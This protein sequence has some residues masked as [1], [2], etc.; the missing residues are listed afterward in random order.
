MSSEEEEVEKGEAVMNVTS[1]KL[2]SHDRTDAFL[3]AG[4][5][6]SADLVTSSSAEWTQ[7]VLYSHSVTLIK[8]LI[9]V[10]V[11][12]ADLVLSSCLCSLV[13]FRTGSRGEGSSL[14]SLD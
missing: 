2:Q 1:V 13:L 4:R 11:C 6:Q 7:V 3:R 9:C 12:S 10:F 8:H 14:D 5:R